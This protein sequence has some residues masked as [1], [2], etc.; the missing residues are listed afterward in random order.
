[1]TYQV[2]TNDY[3]PKVEAT[4]RASNADTCRKQIV[5]LWMQQYREFWGLDRDDIDQATIQAILDELPSAADILADSVGFLQWLVAA[6]PDLLAGDEPYLP[7]KY[8]ASPYA[9]TIDETGRIVLGALSD[10]WQPA[11]ADDSAET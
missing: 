9:M 11:H 4:R 8:L 5:R 2:P 7:P 6:H 1:M 10:D 3:Q